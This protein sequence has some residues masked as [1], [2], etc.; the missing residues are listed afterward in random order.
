MSLTG[1]LQN[2]GPVGCSFQPFL[3]TGHHR[4][5]IELQQ[6]GRFSQRPGKIPLRNIPEVSGVI[7]AYWPRAKVNQ[8]T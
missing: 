5:S 7:R 6:R 8:S 1:Q 2:E 3:Q 4:S